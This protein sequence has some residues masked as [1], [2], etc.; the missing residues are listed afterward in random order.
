[1]ERVNNVPEV[2][3]ELCFG[4]PEPFTSDAKCVGFLLMPNNSEAD[5]PECVQTPQ[6]MG[7]IPRE[8]PSRQV[9][10]MSPGHPRF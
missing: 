1:M 10:V 3:T 6:V 2:V 8:C 4:L 7:S 9:P 5:Y